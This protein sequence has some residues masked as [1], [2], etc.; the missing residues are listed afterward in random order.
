MQESPEVEL[1][2]WAV[3]KISKGNNADAIMEYVSIIVGILK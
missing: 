1:L 2:S 3:I